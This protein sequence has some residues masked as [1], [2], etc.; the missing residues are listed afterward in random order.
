VHHQLALSQARW[1]QCRVHWQALAHWQW[2]LLSCSSLPVDVL[3]QA[4]LAVPQQS[5]QHLVSEQQ[6]Q[7]CVCW[8]CLACQSGQGQSGCE[9]EGAE[10]S[11]W[12]EGRQ[13]QQ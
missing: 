10:V 13:Q 5:Q 11:C 3:F 7:S 9:Q 6:S 8:A 12:L 2:L 4:W 1:G